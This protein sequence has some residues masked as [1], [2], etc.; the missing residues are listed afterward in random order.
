MDLTQRPLKVLV[1]EDDTDLSALIGFTLR[2]AGFQVHTV[3]T[4]RA[5]LTA[6]DHERPDFLL[7]DIN[8]P[9]PNGLDVC[10]TIR[11]RSP[12][13]IMMLTARSHEDDM[14]LA[15]DCGADDYVVK[16]FS[17]RSLLARV[18]ALARRSET[19]T[20][21]T[22]SAGQFQLDLEQHLLTIRGQGQL[23]LTPLE[24]KALHALMTAPGRTVSTDK[25]L[26]HIWG[27]AATRDRRTLK[28]LI[29]RLRQK[30]ER[31]PSV[32]QVLQTTPG[33][34]YKLFIAEES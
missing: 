26:N 32:P 23:L 8:M 16:P 25:L 2:Q 34:G 22:L 27:H 30:L 15:L 33:S 20:L 13:P 21:E 18:K 17:P 12:V 24:T 11:S 4:G 14:I 1:A 29:Y 10:R 28:Q 19:A 6:F 9:E 3:H 7:L 31:D 5:A